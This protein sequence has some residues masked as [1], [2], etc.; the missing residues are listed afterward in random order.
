MDRLPKLPRYAVAAAVIVWAAAIVGGALLAHASGFWGALVDAGLT[1]IATVALATSGL[2]AIAQTWQARE[3]RRR[4]RGLALSVLG[5]ANN[6]TARLAELCQAISLQLLEPAERGIALQV[7]TAFS[8]LPLREED[9]TLLTVPPAAVALLVKAENEVIRRQIGGSYMIRPDE[10]SRML[11]PV[12]AAIRNASRVALPA[13]EAQ[14]AV[15]SNII[16]DVVPYLAPNF[17]PITLELLGMIRARVHTMA[18]QALAPLAESMS[19][20]EVILEK[21]DEIQRGL[22]AA[23]V[24]A[25]DSQHELVRQLNEVRRELAK[26]GGIR[27]PI[28]DWIDRARVKMQRLL[29]AASAWFTRNA[30]INE[31]PDNRGEEEADL[32]PDPNEGLTPGDL[33]K[34]HHHVGEALSILFSTK[35][36]I[37]LC[38]ELHRRLFNARENV[39][40]VPVGRTS[41]AIQLAMESKDEREL[42]AIPPRAPRL[43]G[44]LTNGEVKSPFS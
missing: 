1:T 12:S 17:I 8:A 13:L 21:G 10:A 30:R 34:L 36:L 4:T 20:T 40:N 31:E 7:D 44:S 26:Q 42:A 23:I 28:G 14:S 37:E 35:Q 25:R 32:T 22:Q 15:L 5:E 3:W 6:E 19:T 38:W 24:E 43:I 33:L 39:R 9:A 41:R 11:T 2:A 29:R 18:F 27:L 16:S